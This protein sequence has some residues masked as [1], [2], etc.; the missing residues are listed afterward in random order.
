MSLALIEETS[1]L[2]SETEALA[3]VLRAK[4]QAALRTYLDEHGATL[5]DG[6]TIQGGRGGVLRLVPPRGAF[7]VPEPGAP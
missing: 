3:D 1:R 2:L 6:R 4:R 5:P 7:R